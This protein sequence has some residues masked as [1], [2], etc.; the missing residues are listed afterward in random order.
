M[1]YRKYLYGIIF[2]GMSASRYLSERFCLV[3]TL[4][5]ILLYLSCEEQQY[6]LFVVLA[7]SRAVRLTC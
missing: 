4:S 3:I 5:N 6:Q 7:N 2:R 1:K